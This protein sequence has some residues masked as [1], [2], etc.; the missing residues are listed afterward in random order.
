MQITVN[1]TPESQTRMIRFVNARLK[2]QAPTFIPVLIGIVYALLIL[3]GSKLMTGKIGAGVVFT[4][5]TVVSIVVFMAWALSRT[6]GHLAKMGDCYWGD[7]LFETRE[8]GLHLSNASYSS[9]MR[10]D[11]FKETLTTSDQLLILTG[12]VG[13]YHLPITDGN[14]EA[15][16]AFHDDVRAKIGLPPLT[17]EN[18]A[19]AP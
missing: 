8:D 11:S 17:A 3:T 9:L 16:K 15:I 5:I 6:K 14:R 18:A 10:Y 1:I 4:L 7:T 2:K 19:K 13:G 12:P